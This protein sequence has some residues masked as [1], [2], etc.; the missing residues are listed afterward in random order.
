MNPTSV[1]RS[2][3]QG[4]AHGRRCAGFC[5]RRTPRFHSLLL[6]TVGDRDAVRRVGERE[7]LR[8]RRKVIKGCV[9]SQSLAA[10]PVHRNPFRRMS[11]DMESDFARFAYSK[12][13]RLTEMAPGE[14]AALSTAQVVEVLS[15]LGIRV[16]VSCDRVLDEIPGFLS[17]IGDL[18]CDTKVALSDHVCYTTIKMLVA[19]S[20]AYTDDLEIMYRSCKRGQ[21]ACREYKEFRD[22][23][24]R[25]E[26][27]CDAKLEQMRR[28]I[29][30]QRDLYTNERSP[31][32]IRY[33]DVRRSFSFEF[34]QSR[35][36]GQ[37]EC[38]W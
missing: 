2:R 19:Q 33:D 10:R 3:A 38:A 4:D 35:L 14:I 11:C 20:D 32:S 25:W 5:V 21:A 36:D 15:E 6:A 28:A 26:L 13:A 24:L 23:R 8:G 12:Y 31:I 1:I 9:Q 22:S 18:D 16:D 29:V 17:I 30:A 27:D 7:H 37:D 34:D